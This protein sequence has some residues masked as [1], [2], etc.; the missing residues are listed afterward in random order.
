MSYVASILKVL[1][2]FWHVNDP[3][4]TEDFLYEY[5]APQRVHLTRSVFF[6]ESLG[7]SR[8]KEKGL[9]ED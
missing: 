1:P 2:Q 8:T 4:E 3:S 6:V 7:P 9:L 5:T